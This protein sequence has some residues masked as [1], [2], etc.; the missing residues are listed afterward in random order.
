[1][2]RGRFLRRAILPLAALLLAGGT[3]FFVAYKSFWW[4]F[5][6][7]PA[8]SSPNA[9]PP[10]RAAT[11]PANSPV[12]SA[13]NPA[14]VLSIS[15][16]AIGD[17]QFI[18]P[19]EIASISFDDK[20]GDDETDTS[21]QFYHI[22]NF[23]RGPLQGADLLMA[24]V[25]RTGSPCKG[26]CDES[27]IVRYIKKDN[28]V[29]PL[30]KIS[31][32]GAPADT[33][34]RG[35]AVDARPFTALKATLGQSS[36]FDVPALEYPQTI[37]AGPRA[38]L[39]RRGEGVGVL[40]RSVLQVAFHDPI[41]GDV[42]VTKPGLGTQ[43]A[44]FN[45]CEDVN[46]STHSA[47]AGCTDLPPYIDN[48]FY[49]FRPDGTYLS[50]VYQ[51]DF[52]PEDEQQTT[53]NDGPLPDGVSFRDVTLVGCGWAEADAI[54]VVSP[55]LV[56]ES[57][58]ESI[59][60]V[61][62]TG[63]SLY[64]LKDKSHQL[65]KNFYDEYASAFPTWAAER[66]SDQEAKPVSFDEFVKARP[67]FLWKDP[68]GRLIRFVNTRFVM[69]NACE[70]I[71]Y[72][73]PPREE[74]VQVSL[75]EEVVVVN[76]YPAY[77]QGWLVSA[78]PDGNLTDLR[79]GRKL[80]YLFWEGHSHIL[81]SAT[82]G[83]V[84]KSSDVEVFLEDI[85]PKL[86]LN[87]K[88]ASDFITAWSPKLNQSPYYLITFLDRSVLDRLYPLQIDPPPDNV[89][90]VFMDFRPLRQPMFV[91]PPALTPPPRR[92]GFTVVEWGVLVR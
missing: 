51:P 85:L 70:P 7:T 66:R 10:D 45:R 88:E 55:A 79:T 78:Q 14:A 31:D 75:G 46:P 77:H 40:N 9:T 76:S 62:A 83:F 32:P 92:S 87:A 25:S 43:K 13:T 54:S 23:V 4:P 19:K 47:E 2:E 53:W 82:A 42:W 71:I 81:P 91:E 57:D 33:V 28:V 49:F 84:V 68:F 1:M 59:G 90:R 20:S 21:Y 18:P 16:S 74:D 26:A 65:Y 17:I 60:K 44:F 6:K 34:G 58:L 37:G 89:I 39:Q 8:A 72:L 73:Y 48:A 56:S 22:G 36:D 50:Y 63:D 3:W 29:F 5:H 67:L 61:N 35:T 38:V 86:G 64:G 27:A 80:P 15:G 52:K 12:P 69:L 11:P 30:S 24:S 41:Y